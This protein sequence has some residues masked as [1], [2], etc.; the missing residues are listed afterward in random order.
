[1]G[2]QHN[3]VIKRRR[4]KAYLE[5]KKARL[6]A[7]IARLPSSR[8]KDADAAKP[9]AKKAAKKPAAKKVAK[10]DAAAVVE[11]TAAEESAPAAE[12]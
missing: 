1:M 3:K 12:S 9:A 4:H 2:K 5:R 7:G 8:P 10:K 11:T 6:K